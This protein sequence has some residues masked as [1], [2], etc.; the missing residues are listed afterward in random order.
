MSEL[1]ITTSRPYPARLPSGDSQH[2]PS[3]HESGHDMI[4]LLAPTPL[5]LQKFL[6]LRP[7]YAATTVKIARPRR[8]LPTRGILAFWWLSSGLAFLWSQ[9]KEFKVW[10]WTP[11]PLKAGLGSPL[12]QNVTASAIIFLAHPYPVTEICKSNCAKNVPWSL[13][14]SRGFVI[15]APARPSIQTIGC[16]LIRSLQPWSYTI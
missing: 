7:P 11:T 12:P 8:R 3:S 16:R 9:F 14:L 1:A 10:R 6:S 5:F 13:Y 4:F 15:K 2:G